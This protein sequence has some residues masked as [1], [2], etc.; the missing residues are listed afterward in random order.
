MYVNIRDGQ[1]ASLHIQ[2]HAA[3]VASAR[4]LSRTAVRRFLRDATGCDSYRLCHARANY[5]SVRFRG[6]TTCSSAHV[7]M[8]L[9]TPPVDRRVVSVSV[10]MPSFAGSSVTPA[11]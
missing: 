8:K 9:V 1:I 3:S 5:D 7:P 11:P 6:H 2:S 4:P 10:W